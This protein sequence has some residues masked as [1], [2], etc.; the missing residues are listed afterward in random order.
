MLAQAVG[1]GIIV[2]LVLTETVGLAAGGIVVP[3]YIAYNLHHPWKIVVTILTALLTWLIVKAISRVA[4]IY[5]RR[6]LVISILIGYI[7]GHIFRI[8]PS[9]SVGTHI[10][11]LE[12]IGYV[13]PGLIAY[14]IERQGVISTLL[15]MLTT[16]SLVRLIL[17]AVT[18]GVI[19]P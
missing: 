18:G 1:I 7:L 19:I 17:T 15:M 13:I 9:F 2:S 10:L 3:G 4:L 14:W 6:L 16:A 12:A 5:G 11:D 8:F